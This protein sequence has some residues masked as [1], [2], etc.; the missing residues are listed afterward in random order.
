MPKKTTSIGIV[1]GGA[2]GTALANHLAKKGLKTALWARE[3]EVVSQINQ[4]KM[5]EMFLSGMTL[6]RG[7]VAT[8]HLREGV[9]GKEMILVVV[10]SQHVRGVLKGMVPFLAPQV[11]IGC[12]SKGIEQSS[13]KLLSAVFEE[14]LPKS[15]HWGVA[16]LSGPTFAREVAQGH[17]A[18]L[19]VASH[20]ESVGK[21]FCEVLQTDTF[22]ADWTPDVI[23]IE[24]AGAIKNVVAIACGIS[25]GLDFGY[26]TRAML[27]TRGLGEMVRL[28]IKLGANPETFRGLAGVGDLILTCTGDLS[29]NRTLG[30]RLA[31]GETLE[32]IRISTVSVAEGVDTSKAIYLLAK[33]YQVSLPVCEA[34]YRILFEGL[35][36]QNLLQN[37]S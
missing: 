10:P 36:P 13:L 14:E 16:F 33:K 29:R 5:N 35:P 12:A 26:S 20:E 22:R 24:I 31:K 25:D 28:G 3:S 17:P 8:T 23:G 30:I 7:L 2:W 4:K 18:A 6:H 9:E 27:M 37:L 34:V 15:L 19:N 11:M 1:G 32:K 21:S